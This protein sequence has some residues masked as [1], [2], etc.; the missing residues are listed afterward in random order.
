MLWFFF[1]LARACAGFAVYFYSWIPLGFPPKRSRLTYWKL[2]N[3]NNTKQPVWKT[4]SQESSLI[5]IINW[6]VF[7]IAE[8][9]LILLIGQQNLHFYQRTQQASCPNGTSC[10]GRI[11]QQQT[12][13]CWNYTTVNCKLINKFGPSDLSP[14][15][16]SLS[17]DK[18]WTTSK[19][20]SIQ[21]RIDFWI[22]FGFNLNET[23]RIKPKVSF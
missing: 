8:K 7:S 17:S 12:G 4:F 9:V 18:N 15:W 14:L 20:S 1:C 16:L 10:D 11:L 5:P 2:P 23:W 3:M 13:I 19:R 6:I 22:H 21:W